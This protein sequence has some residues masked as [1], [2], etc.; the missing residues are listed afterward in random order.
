MY[1]ELLFVAY[2]FPSGLGPAI[3]SDLKTPAP[4]T[5]LIQGFPLG[6][7]ME[8]AWIPFHGWIPTLQI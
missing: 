4:I 7:S 3:P 1:C 6:L 8:G 2:R 5:Q